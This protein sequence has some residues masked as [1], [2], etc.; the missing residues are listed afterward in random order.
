MNQIALVTPALVTKNYISTTTEVA[1]YF[2]ATA[3]ID[4]GSSI[5]LEFPAG[6]TMT[7]A[8]C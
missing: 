8:A 6:F 2:K 1:F 3:N 5:K 4:E 7:N